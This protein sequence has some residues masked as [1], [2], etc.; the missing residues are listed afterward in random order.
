MSLITRLEMWMS[1]CIGRQVS[2]GEVIAEVF[3][4]GVTFVLVARVL[5]AFATFPS[6]KGEKQ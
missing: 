5:T 4:F 3:I 1:A 2:I 6:E